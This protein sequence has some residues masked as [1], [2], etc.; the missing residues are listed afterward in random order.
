MTSKLTGAEELVGQALTVPMRLCGTSV[1]LLDY[2]FDHLLTQKED[3]DQD[4]VAFSRLTITAKSRP[5]HQ[6]FR[7]GLSALD[8][9]EGLQV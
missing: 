4:R 5:E 7:Y 2:L 3:N 8:S 6:P 1:L 9:S